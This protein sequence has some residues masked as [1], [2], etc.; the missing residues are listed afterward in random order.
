MLFLSVINYS[1][2]LYFIF[3]FKVHVAVYPN[4]IIEQAGPPTTGTAQP[5]FPNLQTTQP[6]LHGNILSIH[7]CFVYIFINY[8]QF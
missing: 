8:A 6:Q 3:N 2:K 4:K 5:E 1:Y 7:S